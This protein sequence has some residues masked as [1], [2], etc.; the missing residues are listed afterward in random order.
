ME[1]PI[2]LSELFSASHFI[3]YPLVNIPQIFTDERGQ[4]IN[5]ADGTLGDVAFITCKE[6]S[7]RGNHY[8]K[9]DWHLS[10][11]VTGRIKYIWKSLFETEIRQRTIFPGQL[12]Y[13]PPKTLHRMIFEVR[14]E[15]IAISKL[16]RNHTDYE[17][18]L[19]RQ[20]EW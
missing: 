11:L 18:D 2:E 13:T 17:M 6:D 10:F 7:I 3:D 8:R 12:F 15:F 16:N 4:I 14:S 9:E 5:I 19:V 20:S 1:K